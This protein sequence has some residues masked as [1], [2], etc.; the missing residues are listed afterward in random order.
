MKSVGER[1]RQARDARRLSAEALAQLVG[2]KNQSG[3]SNLENRATGTGGTK[4]PAIADALQVPVGWLL[5]G[6]DG[7][8]VPRATIPSA[9][10]PQ[11]WIGEDAVAWS[12]RQSW[13]FPSLDERKVRGL[14]G[15]DAINL[16]GAI[17]L[18]AAQLGL[19]VQREGYRAE[20][21]GT[22]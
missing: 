3:I 12:T 15:D 20:K 5:S 16:Q 18:A 10:P 2:Y 11:H 22:V 19:D 6:P 9:P 7:P 21:T 4:L 17:L 14:T 1:I 13:P 8:E